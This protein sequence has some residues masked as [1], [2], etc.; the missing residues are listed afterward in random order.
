VGIHQKCG[1]AF[2]KQIVREM[3]ERMEK[4]EFTEG[5][6][7]AIRD[8]GAFLREHFPPLPGDVNELPNKIAGD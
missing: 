6:I 2:W 1:D 3:S 5:I 7:C 4:A 8:V